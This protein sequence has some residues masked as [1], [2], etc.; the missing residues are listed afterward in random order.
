[1]NA[2]GIEFRARRE[3]LGLGQSA[4]ADLLG[5]TQPSVARWESGARP[6]PKGVLAE[7]GELED[8]VEDLVDRAL[9]ALEAQAE[10]GEAAGFLFV[11]P[12]DE[13]YQA[14]HPGDATPAVLHRVAMARARA[15]HGDPH[16]RLIT[17]PP[18]TG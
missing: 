5:V 13:A 17:P 11:W 4:L 3:A 12:T 7:L 9:D 1:M 16:L 10:T 8:R 15:T 2:T 18:T 14:A 6:I